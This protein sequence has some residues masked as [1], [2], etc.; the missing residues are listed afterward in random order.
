MNQAFLESLEGGGGRREGTG[1][2]GS[3]RFGGGEVGGG[4]RSEARSG[5]RKDG[6]RKQWTIKGVVVR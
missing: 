6:I 4:G 3:S 1:G 5:R 2:R